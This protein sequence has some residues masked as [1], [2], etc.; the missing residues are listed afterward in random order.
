VY[1]AAW[2]LPH[3]VA[4]NMASLILDLR[5]GPG[6]SHVESCGQG[7]VPRILGRLGHSSPSWAWDED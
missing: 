4:I 3:R 1:M 6:A 2:P 5:R 7:A